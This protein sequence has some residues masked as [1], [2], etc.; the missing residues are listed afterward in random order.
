MNRIYK[1]LLCKLVAL[2]FILGSYN[3]YVA[4]WSKGKPEPD[5]VYPYR[6]STLPPADQEALRKG[7]TAENIIELTRLLEDYLS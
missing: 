5:R 6:V 1:G 7:I 3:G 2:G 4:L